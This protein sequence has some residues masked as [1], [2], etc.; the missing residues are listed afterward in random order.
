MKLLSVLARNHSMTASNIFTPTTFLLFTRFG[1]DDV[2][3]EHSRRQFPWGGSILANFFGM[4]PTTKNKLQTC[5]QFF[6]KI[7]DT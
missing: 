4:T 3:L 2:G 5:L 7:L 6:G 1:D